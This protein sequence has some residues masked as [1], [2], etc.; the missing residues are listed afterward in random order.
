MLTNLLGY[1][2]KCLPTRKGCDLGFSGALLEKCLHSNANCIKGECSSALRS[3]HAS[4][5]I[6]KT[7]STKLGNTGGAKSPDG[8]KNTLKVFGFCYRIFRPRLGLILV[9]SIYGMRHIVGQ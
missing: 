8:I 3:V 2:D 7:N 4:T 6:I 1:F 9:T 5:V